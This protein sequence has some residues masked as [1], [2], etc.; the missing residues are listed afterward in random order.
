MRIETEIKFAGSD[1][2]LPQYRNAPCCSVRAASGG[3]RSDA[4]ARSSI[5][6][7]W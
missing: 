1:A 6:L 3:R 7:I 2:S 5:Y 4:D